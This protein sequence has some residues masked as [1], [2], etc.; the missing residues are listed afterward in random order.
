MSV[1]NALVDLPTPRL[2]HLDAGFASYPYISGEPLSRSALAKLSSKGRSR[3]LDQLA[4]FHR[5][6]HGIPTDALAA[7]NVPA[8]PT[9]RTRADWLELHDR[10]QHTLFPHLWAHQR[11]WV[12]EL[13][14]PILHG[15]LDLDYS[16]TL[17]HGD[18]AIYHIF[19]DPDRETLT[20][21]I[22]FGVAGLG[23][24]ACDIAIQLSNYGDNIVQPMIAKNPDWLDSIDRARFLAATL[25]LQW[26]TTGIEQNDM[27]LLLAHIGGNRELRT[28][29]AHQDHLRNEGTA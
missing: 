6:L 24:P 11:T 10:V 17:I 22:D 12:A 25:E 13:F 28:A 4:V 23:D 27:S 20:G 1:V 15:Q 16:P 26:T 29:G 7:A 18:L 8:S 5:Q 21:V 3:V 9:Q 14:A 19:H 2:D